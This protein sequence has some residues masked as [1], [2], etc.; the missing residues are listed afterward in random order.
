MITNEL[1]VKHLVLSHVFRAHC[2]ILT[3]RVW[4]RCRTARVLE[5]R[6]S[7][8]ALAG[9]EM[10]KFHPKTYSSVSRQRRSFHRLGIAI[11]GAII[12]V[13]L[14]LIVAAV[15]RFDLFETL[16]ADIFAVVTGFALVLLGAI[17][18]ATYGEIRAI[19]WV[20]RGTL[21]TQVNFKKKV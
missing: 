17:A 5:R 7:S 3:K 1:S 2:G 12:A 21:R 14:A 20:S 16:G 9:I 13:G 10:D 18:I 15:S 6:R 11:A 19:E 4:K 8:A